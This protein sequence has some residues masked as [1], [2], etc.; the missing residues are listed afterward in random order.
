MSK[1]KRWTEER[2]RTHNKEV[3]SNLGGVKNRNVTNPR[4]IMETLGISVF[5]KPVKG[6]EQ[7]G[8]AAHQLASL[9]LECIKTNKP[10][11]KPPDM[12]FWVKVMRE[13]LEEDKR[14]FDSVKAVIEWCQQEDGFWWDKIMSPIDLRHKFDKL[15]AGMRR[16]SKKGRSDY[17]MLDLVYDYMHLCTLL[18][19]KHG[20]TFSSSGEPE[21]WHKELTGKGLK[22][23]SWEAFKKM[24]M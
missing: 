2:Q 4:E 22:F 12:D 24:Y 1:P 13:I 16:E 8:I 21:D 14:E 23:T 6:E 9:L 20:K 15:E 19:Y 5:P 18:A 7:R 10:D 17:S 3:K 11:F